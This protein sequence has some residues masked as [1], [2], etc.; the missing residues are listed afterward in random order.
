VAALVG[1]AITLSGLL[2]A[3]RVWFRPTKYYDR[4]VWIQG[5]G[6]QYLRTLPIIEDYHYKPNRADPGL[7]ADELIRGGKLEDDD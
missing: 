3:S 7:S 1:I 6:R 5:A 4:F 2:D